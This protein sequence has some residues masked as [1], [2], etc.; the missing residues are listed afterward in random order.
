MPLLAT[1][2]N[3]AQM[4]NASPNTFELLDSLSSVSRFNKAIA[5]YAEPRQREVGGLIYGWGSKTYICENRFEE[6]L[7]DAFSAR[8]Y[9]SLYNQAVGLLRENIQ[10]VKVAIHVVTTFENID[11]RAVENFIRD[12]LNNVERS[13][14]SVYART[15]LF[16]LQNIRHDHFTTAKDCLHEIVDRACDDVETT[17]EHYKEIENTC[18]QQHVPTVDSV[19][20]TSKQRKHPYSRSSVK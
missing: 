4:F 16:F 9:E 3:Y 2:R 20:R 13:M 17:I 18:L 15:V 11:D 14:R 12:G 1:L 19:A 7:F 10:L 5:P 8:R 6:L